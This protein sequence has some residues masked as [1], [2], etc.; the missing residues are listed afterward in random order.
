VNERFAE[1]IA[2]EY[3]PGDLI[4]VHDYQLLLVPGMLRQRLRDARI[5]FFL[6]IPFPADEVFRVLPW[7]RDILEGLL[8][9]DLIGFHTYSYVQHFAA[10]LS[11]LSGV[12]PEHDRVWLDD[13]EVRLGA[14]PMG[15]DASA[16]RELALSP[17]IEAQ[18]YTIR[19]EAHDR[20][21]LLGVDRLDYTKGILR[22]LLALE[23]LLRD[24]PSL[25]GRIRLIQVAVPSRDAVASYQ[26][27]GREVDQLVG[28]INGA[29]GTATSVPIHY[30]HQ[31]ISHDQL[32]ALYRSADVMLV[33]PLRDGMNLVAKEYI[34]SRVDDD[35]VLVLSEFAGAAEEL[36]EAVLVNAYDTRDLA[37]KIRLALDM[38]TSECTRRMRALRRRVMAHDV[39]RWAHEFLGALERDPGSGTRVTA[40]TKRSGR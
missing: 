13:R 26:E 18:V 40:G 32:V 38:P 16:F 28:R 2:G 37:D 12:E 15:I 9:A 21:I 24:D 6:H 31:S 1:C 17:A 35:G 39:H 29:Y 10:A 4:W 25:C 23:H 27:F 8:G 30:V 7:R 14:F 36:H 11:D 22:R 3:R 19:R 33:T 34:A 5:G 20:M